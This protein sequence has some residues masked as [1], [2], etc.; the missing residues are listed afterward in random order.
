MLTLRGGLVAATGLAVWAVGRVFGAGPLEQLGVAF[1]A[2]VAI[3]LA[4]ARLSRHDLV[5]DRLI[6][7]H[8]CHAGQEVAVTLELVNRGKGPAPLILIE[9]ALPCDLA[10]RARFAVPG[11]EAAGRRSLRYS[12]TPSRRG[13]YDV[14]PAKVTFVDPFGLARAESARR[15]RS[16]VLVHPRV[17][18]LALPRDRGRQRSLAVSA[19]RR[20]VGLNGEDFYTLREYAE[21]DD[22]RRV[23][24]PSTARSRK[25]MIRQEEAAWH[26]RATVLFDDRSQAHEGVGEASSF[27]R[28]IEAA[29]S[30][31]DLYQRSGYSY[32]LMGAS[33][34][35]LPHGRRAGHLAACLD[36]LATLEASPDEPRALAARLAG[37]DTGAAPEGTLAAVLG[38]AVDA[39]SAA[40]LGRLTRRFSRVIAVLHP[41]HRFGGRPTRDRWAGEKDAR[42]VEAVLRR[43]GVAV[44]ALGPEDSLATA[45]GA[46]S[47]NQPVGGEREWAPKPELV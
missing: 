32:R 31:A 24:W 22:L 26:T 4:V 35:G 44:I 8:R 29:A 7:P 19:L 9:D 1:I 47:S 20:P 12:V 15:E 39:G 34:P 45:W 17:H 42:D 10:T 36:L 13:R 11:I 2:L 21:G 33:H 41:P 43:A 25:Y 37:L 16:A 5:V 27:E 18:N 46:L 6:E 30:L 38:G 28:M 3:A 23:H 40:L 14:G